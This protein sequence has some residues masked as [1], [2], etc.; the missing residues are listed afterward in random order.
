MSQVCKYNEFTI[1][2]FSHNEVPD[3]RIKYDFALF[4][5]GAFDREIIFE[6]SKN[7]LIF[8]ANKYMQ[9]LGNCEK[10]IIVE[11]GVQL[12]F[13]WTSLKGKPEKINLR[14][15]K[16]QLLDYLVLTFCK[17]KQKALYIGNSHEAPLAFW[18]NEIS[19]DVIFTEASIIDKFLKETVEQFLP[20]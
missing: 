12:I 17:K 4:E 7:Q 20:F 8:E 1:R 10:Y 11:N 18:R 15:G 13:L 9:Q 19:C 5:D 3:L 14:G 2:F 6:R 16:K